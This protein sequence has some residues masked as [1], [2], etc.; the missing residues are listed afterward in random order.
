MLLTIMVQELSTNDDDDDDINN[1]SSFRMLLNE[2]ARRR[3]DHRIPRAALQ[4]PSM[5][6]WAFLYG[7]GNDQAL[8]T[9]CG[10]DHDAFRGLLEIFE[11]LFDTHTPF[12][13]GSGSYQFRS[14]T[15]ENRGRPRCLDAAQC[16]GMCLMWTRTRG[17]QWHI[18]LVFGTTGS[19]TNIWIRFGIQLL[20]GILQ[21]HDDAKMRY[22][23][24]DE[25]A[26]CKAAVLSRHSALTDVYCFVDGLKLYLEQAGNVVIQNYFYNGWTH[27][28]YVNNVLAFLP[29]GK[30]WTCAL[31]APG[32]WHD[33]VIAEM[34]G[35]YDQFEVMWEQYHG[36]CLM[37]SAFSSSAD[38]PY[39]LKSSQ[40]DAFHLGAHAALERTQAT[41]CRQAA[42]WG[43]RAYQSSFPRVKDRFIYETNGDRVQMLLFITLLY[44]YRA[45][46]V[47]LNQIQTVYM[48]YLSQDANRLLNIA[49]VND[50]EP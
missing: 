44:N 25:V 15:N 37:D 24:A 22:P 40:D 42:E 9:A 13:D 35:L 31:N 1:V 48:F 32:S 34:G 21:H 23:T 43:M 16:L 4:H 26:A 11:P 30:I 19:T 38:K 8:I 28:H 20:V 2:E 33:S 36:K 6:A 29:N 5:S 17:A 45:A 41:S 46:N 18:G 3:R 10:L 14:L 12:R 27:D 50:D 7:S 49:T 47:G 39:V